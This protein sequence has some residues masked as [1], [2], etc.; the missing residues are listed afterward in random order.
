MENLGGKKTC[1]YYKVC[2]NVTN[3]LKC[4]GYEKRK[5]NRK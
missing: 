5:E 3:C 4:K 1:K 2:G